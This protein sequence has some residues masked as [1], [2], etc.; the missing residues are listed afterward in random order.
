MSRL[1]SLLLDVVLVLV[2]ATIG[3]RSHAEGL[4]VAGVLDT[5]WPFLA[6]V[7][8]GHLIALGLRLRASTLP[9]GA[10]VWVA[11]VAGG[12]LLRRATGDGTDPAFVVVATLVLGVF[13]LG[14]RLVT[15]LGARRRTRSAPRPTGAPGRRP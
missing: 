3:R 15:R 11:A 10:V 8:L 14:W 12:M 6:G 7:L 5:A 9:A 1:V 13:L 4:S 2:F